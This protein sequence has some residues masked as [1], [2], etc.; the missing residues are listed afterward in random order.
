MNYLSIEDLEMEIAIA[1]MMKELYLETRDKSPFSNLMFQY[2][3][4]VEIG[5]CLASGKLKPTTSEHYYNM[6][7]SEY[8][9]RCKGFFWNFSLGLRK[10]NK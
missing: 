9:S 1:V 3:C 10:Y 6:S 4:G 8:V 2:W 7:Y 5:L